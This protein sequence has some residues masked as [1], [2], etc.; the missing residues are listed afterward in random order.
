MVFDRRT[1]PP[2][3]VASGSTGWVSAIESISASGDVLMPLVIHRGK[4]LTSLPN[5]WFPPSKE[6]PNW[7]W[8][9]SDKGWTDNSYAIEW[10]KEIFIPQSRRDRKADD[11]SYW[12]LL[13]L[14]GHGSHCTG[15]FIFEC[16]FNQ[17]VL[18]YL[19]PHTSHLCQPCDLGPFS[20]LKG[21]YSKNLK[22]FIATGQTQV[23]RAE[24]DALYYL[25]RQQGFTAQYIIAGW[26]RSG[27]WPINKRKVLLKPE[28]S[29]YRQITPNLAPPQSL[30]NLTP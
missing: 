19:L 11:K 23:S 4:K 13:I 18:V 2:I 25:T 21:F 20:R 28:I 29:R 3:S 16:I 5:C 10:L 12:R 24:F 7:R 8:G 15:E 1:G 9:F 17:I 22:S 6:C 27:L 26:Y 14:D 30:Q